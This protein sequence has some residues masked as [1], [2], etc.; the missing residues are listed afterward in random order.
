MTRT[1][2]SFVWV[3]ASLIVASASSD[4]VAI[5]IDMNTTI[6]FVTNDE[7]VI[8]VAGGNSKP[9]TTVQ[10]VDP[11][12]FG[13]D[14]LIHDDS[15]V[16]ILGGRTHEFV[17]AFDESTVFVSGGTLTEELVL[18]DSSRAIVSGGD[19][20][21][22]D[23]YGQACLRVTGGNDTF[24]SWARDQAFVEILGGQLVPNP[25]GS[26]FLA[27]GNSRFLIYGGNFNY[28]LGPLAD[29]TG[30]LTGILSNGGAIDVQFTIS[31]GASI[32]L[33]PEPASWITAFSGG[34][35]LLLVARRRLRCAVARRP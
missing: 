7:E 23:L 3:L 19:L 15:I 11:A 30:W 8:V 4:A 22:I 21:E 5:T 13:E 18:R 17:R 29:S 27:E 28:P 35:A 1:I 26:E 10:I 14:L 34:I 32:T 16:H 20:D 31:D 9:P 24:W 33:V 12:E 25:F 6:D 2:L